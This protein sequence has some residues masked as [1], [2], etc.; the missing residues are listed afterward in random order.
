MITVEDVIQ[1]Q[2]NKSDNNS[3]SW[4]LSVRLQSSPKNP[5]NIH[6]RPFP[7]AMLEAMLRYDC[8]VTRL[9]EQH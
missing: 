2:V 5:R 9:H 3:L 6:A 4:P 1:K 8:N 7:S